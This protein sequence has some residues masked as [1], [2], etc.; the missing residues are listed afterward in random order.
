M[1]FPK[2]KFGNV[3]ENSTD[4]N[5]PSGKPINP[6]YV[7]SGIIPDEVTPLVHKV[8]TLKNIQED[9]NDDVHEASNQAISDYDDF[10]QDVKNTPGTELDEKY[11]QHLVKEGRYG[12]LNNKSFDDTL[13]LSREADAYNNKPIGK[14]H[15][16]ISYNPSAG[17]GVGGFETT[18][19]DRPKIETQEMRQMRANERLDEMQRGLDVQLQHNITKLPYEYFK[20][21]MDEKYNIRTSEAEAKRAFAQIRAVDRAQQTMSQWGTNFEKVFNA[22]YGILLGPIMAELAK[23]N[24]LQSIVFANAALGFSAIPI[25]DYYTYKFLDPYLKQLMEK[26]A[27]KYG[28]DPAKGL[29]YLMDTMNMVNGLLGSKAEESFQE[30]ANNNGWTKLFRKR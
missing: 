2:I 10:Y 18:G 3:S 1:A 28:N 14:M 26:G 21:T 17:Q 5:S 24:T 9:F 11:N 23:T 19:Y 30:H 27:A 6:E 8:P 7:N 13:K 12:N 25:Q 22:K 4:K 16:G 20:K 29:Q 15:L